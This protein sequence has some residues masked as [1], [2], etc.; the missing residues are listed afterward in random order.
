MS[1]E[2]FL[3]HS[4]KLRVGVN[5][6]GEK[7]MSTITLV[8]HGQANTNAKDEESYDQLSALGRDQAAWLG[9]YFQESAEPFEQVFSGTL[10]RQVDTAINI[11]A[12]DPKRDPRLNEMRYFDL[13]MSAKNEHGISWPETREDFQTHLPQLLT[14][15]QA[16]ALPD[17]PE[18]FAAFE[19]RVRD[20]LHNIASTKGPSLVVTSGGVIAMVMRLTLGLDISAMARCC[21]AIHNTSVHKYTALATGL[22]LTQ[23][24]AVP[25]LERPD[26]RYALTHL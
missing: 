13:A 3:A 12:I 26:R 15:W 5:N 21:L 18:T 10:Q 25:H 9:A 2:G 6:R 7:L 14:L 24:N 20:T 17:A 19:T 11:Q 23:F 22:G 4:T 8:R 1:V 16:D